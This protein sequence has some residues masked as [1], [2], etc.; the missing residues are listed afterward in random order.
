MR[1]LGVK[2]VLLS[3]C[4]LIFLDSCSKFR[5][6]QKSED[7]K[8]K[9]EAALV[10]YKTEDY[11]RASVLFEEIMPLIRG[12]QEGELAQFYYA[13]CNYY[14]KQYQLASYYF[15]SFYETYSRS[16]YA[17][18]AEFMNAYSLYLDSP[19]F[20]LDQTSTKEAIQAMQLFI[21]KNYT[22]KYSNE[23]NSIINEMQMKLQVKA[24]NNAKQYYKMRYYK[25]AIIAFDNYAIDYPD[26]IYNE[27]LV[28]LK[29]KAQNLLA[30]A[31][32]PSKKKERYSEAIIFYQ[33]FLEDYPES[34]YSKEADRIYDGIVNTLAKIEKNQALQ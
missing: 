26:A 2:I 9:Y 17:E 29:F 25:S 20:N 15:K 19:I 5:K 10:Y 3:V 8:V 31:S 7:W 21:N 12:Q 33:D 18:E 28:F 14:Q 30:D 24:Y 22:G 13:Y 1:K 6:V 16:E 32:I 4:I 27:E 34:E 23:A 11:Y